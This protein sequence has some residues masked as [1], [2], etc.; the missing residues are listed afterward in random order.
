MKG[1]HQ[2][3]PKREIPLCRTRLSG[4]E[5]EQPSREM[6]MESP[7]EAKARK[8]QNVSFF[9]NRKEFSTKSE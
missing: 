8:S 1:I 3:E 6:T 5:K 7:S 2:V 9:K 4:S